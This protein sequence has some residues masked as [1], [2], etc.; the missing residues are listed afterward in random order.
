MIREKTFDHCRS[1]QERKILSFELHV[2][3]F[4]SWGIRRLDGP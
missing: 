2:E 1:L 4:G 3:V